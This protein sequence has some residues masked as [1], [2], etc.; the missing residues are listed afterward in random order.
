[1]TIECPGDD[2]AATTIAEE[3][4]IEYRQLM[5]GKEHSFP[6]P[7]TYNKQQVDELVSQCNNNYSHSI[8]THDQK[9]NVL[10][11]YP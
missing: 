10:N 8:F 1:M 11:V 5:L 7:S 3:F 6:I 4:Q 9:N 2:E